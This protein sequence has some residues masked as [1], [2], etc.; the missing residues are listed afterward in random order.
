MARTNRLFL[1]LWQIYTKNNPPEYQTITMYYVLIF[2]NV[3]VI[4]DANDIN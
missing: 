4:I 1:F 2:N 3:I